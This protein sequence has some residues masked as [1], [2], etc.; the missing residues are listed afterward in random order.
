MRTLQILDFAVVQFD[1]AAMV[2]IGVWMRLEVLEHK[3]EACEESNPEEAWNLG[4][5][6]SRLSEP[7]EHRLFVASGGAWRGYFKLS[8]EALYNP[9]DATPYTILF[10]TRTWKEI[11]PIPTKRFRGVTYRVPRLD[12]HDG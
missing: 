10:D 4:V 5:W 8:S 3:L 9:K 1:E 12:S 2:D 7:G 11:A 6:P